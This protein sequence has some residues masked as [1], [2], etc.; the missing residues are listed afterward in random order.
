LFD[1]NTSATVSA[2]EDGFVVDVTPTQLRFL[3][4]F[5]EP[6]G[7][8]PYAITGAGPSDFSLSGSFN[9]AQ[10]IGCDDPYEPNNSVAEANTTALTIGTPLYGSGSLGGDPND[11]YRFTVTEAGTHVIA[12][13]WSDDAD[14]DIYLR[15]SAGANMAGFA[16]ATVAKPERITMNLPAGDYYVQTDFY[17]SAGG[18]CTTFKITVTPQS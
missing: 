4:P 1:A 8:I 13:D 15:N 3:L 14:L 18:P 17:D 16:G 9:L 7:A 12:I 6:A 10:A 11:F 5:G 2:S